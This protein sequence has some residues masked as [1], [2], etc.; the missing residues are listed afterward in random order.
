MRAVQGVN[1]V[2][3]AYVH[4]I[5]SLAAFG[6]SYFTEHQQKDAPHQVLGR[7]HRLANHDWYH[8]FGT[9][10][11]FEHPTPGWIA[12]T[13]EQLGK[14]FGAEDAE[15]YQAV[16]LAHDFTDRLHDSDSPAERKLST[17]AHIF[18]LLHPEILEAKC[19]VDV[20]NGRIHRVIDG[21]EVWESNPET[22]QDYERLR[23][24][25]EKVLQN[26]PEMQNIVAAFEKRYRKMLRSGEWSQ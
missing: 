5:E 8:A 7:E 26:D 25:V 9:L 17:A 16:F 12:G 3:N 2:P 21:Q 22:V 14:A 6:R 18:L 11:N 24:Y 15:V 1:H 23:S 19:G 13:T 4:A 10:W 20:I